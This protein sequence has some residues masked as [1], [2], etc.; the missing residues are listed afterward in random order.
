MVREET[1]YESAWGRRK[2]RDLRLRTGERSETGEIEQRAVAPSAVPRREVTTGYTLEQLGFLI[3][4]ASAE[5]YR[6]AHEESSVAP[7]S[8]VL[9]FWILRL[10]GGGTVKLKVGLLFRVK[11]NGKSM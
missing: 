10:C 11:R 8:Y 7:R 2:G 9:C 1:E 4:G 3:D 6:G 5:R